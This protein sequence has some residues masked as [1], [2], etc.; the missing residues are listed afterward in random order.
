M[1]DDAGADVRGKT[2]EQK[3]VIDYLDKCVDL[4]ALVTFAAKDG[5]DVPVVAVRFWI[6][7][8]SAL[9]P[10]RTPLRKT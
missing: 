2:D 9:S 3:L 6:R 10:Q 1:G 7:L 4:H 8:R 5:D